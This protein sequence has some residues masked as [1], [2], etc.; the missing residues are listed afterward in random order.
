MVADVLQGALWNSVGIFRAPTIMDPQKAHKHKR[1]K[2]I[3]LPYLG[4]LLRGFIW[5]I[6]NPKP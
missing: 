3:S 6:P 2:G 5:D 4:F 1:F